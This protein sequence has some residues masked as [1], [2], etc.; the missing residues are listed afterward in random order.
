M[1][2]I[3]RAASDHPDFVDLVKKLDRELWERYDA[4]QAQ[5]DQHNKIE[6]NKMVLVAYI[7]REAVG[8]ACLKPAD[9]FTI[10]I[11]RMFVLPEHRGKGLA[12]ALMEELERWANQLS[13]KKMILQTAYKQP[14]AVAVYKKAGF[15]ITEPYEPYVGMENSICM[16]KTIG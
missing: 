12:M 3:L 8:C 7:A 11:K 6:N 16:A 2:R 5:F 14:E 1:L 13:Y 9:A 10:E 15:V 4:E